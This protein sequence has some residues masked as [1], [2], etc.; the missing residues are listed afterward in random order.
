MQQSITNRTKNHQ[1]CITDI[2][3]KSDC[4]GFFNLLTGPKLL[5]IVEEQLPD[6]RERIYTP[7]V[8]L[9]LFISQTLSSDGSC[10]NI[11]NDYVEK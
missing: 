3:N 9:S 4:Y 10:Q 2:I 1:K 11:V 7:T 8:T 6:Y 5:D